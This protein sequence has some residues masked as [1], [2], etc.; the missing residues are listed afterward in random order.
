MKRIIVAFA[1]VL[2]AHAGCAQVLV[3]KPKVSAEL[4]PM[5]RELLQV[6]RAPQRVAS[7]MRTI[8]SFDNFRSPGAI[9]ADDFFDKNKT[10]AALDRV[11]ET[12]NRMYKRLGELILKDANLDEAAWY[13]YAPLYGEG[14][15]ADELRSMIGFYRTPLGQK[16]IERDP[17]FHLW[18]QIRAMEFFGA[19]I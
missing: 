7:T 17:Q 16:I 8:L 10:Q 5:I 9:P 6:T 4:E 19:R 18:E 11:S 12:Q 13:V 3:E 1:A 15:T 14:W 2:I